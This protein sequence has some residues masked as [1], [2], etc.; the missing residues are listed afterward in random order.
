M[1]TQ[2][3]ATRSE[4]PITKT[5]LLE[6]TNEI[7]AFHPPLP[8]GSVWPIFEPT[9]TTG[10]R[11]PTVRLSLT[12][13]EV[14]SV[15][16]NDGTELLVTTSHSFPLNRFCETTLIRTKL[17]DGTEHTD[18]VIVDSEPEPLAARLGLSEDLASSPIKRAP[19]GETAFGRPADREYFLMIDFSLSEA[20]RIAA[21]MLLVSQSLVSKL[22]AFEACLPQGAGGRVWNIRKSQNREPMGCHA[23]TDSCGRGCCGDATVDNGRRTHGIGFSLN[24]TMVRNTS[25]IG[26]AIVIIH[27]IA[28][29]FGVLHHGWLNTWDFEGALWASHNVNN[30]TRADIKTYI[31]RANDEVGSC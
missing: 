6:D 15:A 30:P 2:K 1:S 8:Y 9:A 11:V 21:A 18:V 26:I 20:R 4:V 14:S 16:E 17:Q 10:L 3:E 31:K 12:A 29:Q 7:V 19:R 22:G 24:P 28:H 23:S 25:E 13:S 5:L 27:E